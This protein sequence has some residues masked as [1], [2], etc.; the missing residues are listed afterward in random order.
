MAV[1]RGQLGNREKEERP[2]LEAGTRGLVT[3]QQIGKTQCVCVVN[4]RLFEN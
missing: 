1:A 4:C 3:G 2:L